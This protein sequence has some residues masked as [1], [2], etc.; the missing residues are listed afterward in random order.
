[1]LLLT[2]I[3][4]ALAIAGS[5]QASSADQSPAESDILVTA[6]RRRAVER[7]VDRVT[8]EE[9]RRQIARWNVPLCVKYEDVSAPV[10]AF[11]QARIARAARTV[12]L[13]VAR[14]GCSENVLIKL[15][16][17]A[18]QLARAWV[19]LTPRR[20]GSASDEG[21]PSR[22]LV[23][24][25]E[26]PRVVRWMTLTETINRDGVRFDDTTAKPA[27]RLVSASLIRSSTREVVRSKIVLIDSIRLKEV[28]LRQLA[29]HIAFVV[30][31]SPDIAADFAGQNSIMALFSGSE[32]PAEMTPQDVRFLEALYRTPPDRPPAAQTGLL[33]E[34]M[35]RD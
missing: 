28:T 11:V 35:M 24:A 23:D 14:K 31:A 32:R 26:A 30:L 22:R 10:A 7:Y 6:S 34:H 2:A 8:T 5:S 16:D 27:N 4:A 1:M 20:V 3:L 33:V 15:S 17:Q 13:G 18:D 25:I 19:R 12:G 9:P 21:L 29:D